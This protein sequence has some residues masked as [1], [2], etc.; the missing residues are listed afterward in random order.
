MRLQVA[1]RLD[2]HQIAPN[3]HHRASMWDAGEGVVKGVDIGFDEGVDF[4]LSGEQANLENVP[5]YKMS[6][7]G[8]RYHPKPK[9][10]IEIDEKSIQNTGNP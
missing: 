3:H 5:G 7:S 10:L 2:M 9:E 1:T 6:A 4:P 8:L